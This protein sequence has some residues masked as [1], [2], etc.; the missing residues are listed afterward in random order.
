MLLEPYRRGCLEQ[1]RQF[2]RGVC[3][4]GNVRVLGGKV[5][6]TAQYVKAHT[7]DQA[8]DLGKF[9]ITGFVVAGISFCTDEKERAI[10]TLFVSTIAFVV[11]LAR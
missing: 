2:A 8:N 10:G 7:W 6:E 1:C 9:S 5:V 3:D 4:P 11:S